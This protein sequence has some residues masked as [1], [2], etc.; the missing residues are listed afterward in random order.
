MS[1]TTIRLP[2]ELKDRVAAAAEKT[3]KTTHSFIIEA[4]AE[5]TDAEE[6]RSHFHEIAEKRYAGIVATGE[7]IPWSEMRPYLA[8]R[9]TGK[10]TRSPAPRKLAR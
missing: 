5:K 7:T 3:G 10:K 9:V 8:G 6:R 1:T 4:I 2:D